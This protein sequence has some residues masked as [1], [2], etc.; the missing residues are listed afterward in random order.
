MSVIVEFEIIV[1]LQVLKVYVYTSPRSTL[2]FKPTIY[3][4]LLMTLIDFLKLYQAVTADFPIAFG[5]K[6]AVAHQVVI[7]VFK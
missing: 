4:K 2:S 6:R 7:I 3:T 5:A 1:K